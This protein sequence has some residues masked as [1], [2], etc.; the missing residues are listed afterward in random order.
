M[1][2]RIQIFL[3]ALTTLALSGAEAFAQG[4][5]A[6]NATPLTK[7]SVFQENGGVFFPEWVENL[8]VNS[9]E[10][11]DVYFSA[12]YFK[13]GGLDDQL[14]N[15]P[16]REVLVPIRSNEQLVVVS[17]TP[18]NVSEETSEL[19]RNS[20]AEAKEIFKGD[21]YP[22]QSVEL[23][24]R[25]T[26]NGRMYQYIRIYPI[27]VNRTGFSIR[28]AESV[29]YRLS[30]TA[31][32]A[33][34]GNGGHT[35][36]NRTYV[37]NSTLA[38]GNWYKLGI[39]SDGVY[40]LD[41]SYFNSLGVD[42]ATIDP[43]T[44]RIHANGGGMLP[45]EA[46]A[47]DRDDLVENA[48]S[49]QGEGDGT[50]NQG[51]YVLFYAQGPHD[52][53]LHPTLDRYV[54][55]YNVYS[56][57]AF[58]FL[59]WGNGTG[60]RIQNVPSEPSSNFSP[61]SVRKYAF[62]EVDN[63]NAIT[64]GRVWLGES[65]DFTTDRT[66]SFSM[67][68]ASPGTDVLITTRVAA[69]S[70]AGSGF[71]IKENGNTLTTLS[72]PNINSAIYG[73][74]YYRANYRSINYPASNIN[75]GSLDL[76]FIYDKPLTSSV[77]YLDYIEMEYRA[78]LN[79]SGAN[80]W[81][82]ADTDNVGPGSI[83]GINLLGGNTAY[84]VW[85]VTDLTN[86]EGR[87]YTMNGGAMSF[88]MAAESPREMVA[89]VDA[90]ART[91]VSAQ[92]VQNQNLHGLGAAD[93]ILIT[94]PDFMVSAN[95]LANFHRNQLGHSV[96]VVS[97]KDIYNEFS[98][99]AQDPAAI[100]DFLKMFYDRHQGTPDA[101]R[102]VLLMGDGSYDYK[103]RVNTGEGSFI[104][105]YQSRKSQRPTES[106]TSD[107]FYG[108][109]ADG[110]GFWGE[111][112]GLEGGTV[113]I[114]YWVEGDTV[115][116]THNLQV[117]IGRLPVATAQEAEE[118]VSK[119]TNYVS[120][121]NGLG[122][123]RNRILLVADHKDDDGSIHVSQSN[124]YSGQI[125]AANGC[126][127]IDKLFMDNYTMVNTASGARFPD[128]KEALLKNL[129]Q[130][131]L[132]VNYT[133]H[134][135]EIGWSNSSILDISDINNIANDLKLPAYVTATCEF[136]RW[137]DPGRRSGAEVLFLRPDGGSIA[138]F[139]TVRV[140]YSGPNYILNQNFYDYAFQRDTAEN[141]PLTMGEIFMRTKNDSWLGSIN[142]RNFTLMGDPGISLNYPD[143]KTVVNTINGNSALD[144]VVDTI[145]ALSLVTITGEVQ[146]HL[147]NIQSSFNGDLA[148][149]VFDKPTKFITKRSP[150]TFLWQ[151]NKVFNGQASVTNGAF[152]FQFVVPVDISYE[153][154]LGK[155]SVYAQNMVTDAG[156]CDGQL[157]VGGTGGNITDDIGPELDLYMNDEHWADGNMVDP[158][159]LMFA[160]VYD[161]NGINTVGTGI[162][163]E[164]TGI[165]D[166]KESDVIILNDFYQADKNSYQ[167]GT[168][169]YPFQNL[170]LGEHRLEVKVWDVANNSSAKT[171]HFLVVDDASMA[172]GHVL[173]YPNPFTSNT[174]FFIEHNMNGHL[175]DVRVKIFTVGGH[176]VKSLD[177][178]FLAEGN[179]YCDMEWDGL[180]EYGD[181]LGR[182]VYVYQVTVT[183]HDSGEKVNRFEKLVLLR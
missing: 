145:G 162:G 63:Y 1:R 78:Q 16:F 58:V 44:I 153:E 154:G 5:V 155:V 61:A 149:T 31:Y 108:F 130:G 113:D 33:K 13:Q 174:K 135:G 157:F 118:V 32:V 98:C 165:L 47:W 151:K 127:N 92:Q 166:G 100:R 112:A 2:Y 95:T 39:T 176:L 143:L 158:N 89:F 42:P 139:T 64:S 3:L 11:L 22:A 107:D 171:I 51:D 168:I 140:V 148:V 35:A 37:S 105:T 45:Q 96:H 124:S 85:D 53:Y 9:R 160:N 86:V 159:P 15:L 76:Q 56:D 111:K 8:S 29:T 146:D 20:V 54:H 172:L 57:T 70:N 25:V 73:S 26:R 134:G 161:E 109:L 114:L 97:V 23:G 173:N 41:Y 50:F 132:L 69:H 60:K 74:Y 150:Y 179:L 19:F 103:N 167:R 182:G 141:R 52:W 24:D 119:I 77:G 93:Y 137:D 79:M 87:S 82:F 94:H 27:Q 115:T 125:E 88:N 14:V 21:W 138:M 71:T 156:G 131:S 10:K 117:A 142:N 83:H 181:V 62:H 36:S 40:K 175:L 123:W 164:L 81:R 102:Y 178:T 183:D 177:D 126:M 133:G 106:Y 18:N 147:G 99:G 72:V 180:D 6:G 55:S 129:D 110:D 67:P 59:T 80:Y 170:S 66:F 163:H 12:P 128:G 122:S 7:Q 116:T 144:M 4:R 121:P 120:S 34:Q 49:V 38:S 28:K 30:R 46:G 17:A 65:F 101:L 68:N 104:P 48:I 169:E 91:P 75:D 43:R 152:S 136:G 90:G 84:R